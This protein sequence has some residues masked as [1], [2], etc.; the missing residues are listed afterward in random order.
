[1]HAYF[2][3]KDIF[4]YSDLVKSE[5]LLSAEAKNIKDIKRLGCGDLECAQKQADLF[6]ELAKKIYEDA[7]LTYDGKDNEEIK[8][9]MFDVMAEIVKLSIRKE[10]E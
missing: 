9:K 5:H 8:N 4:S 3:G 7:K 1:M 6:L 10:L 2:Y